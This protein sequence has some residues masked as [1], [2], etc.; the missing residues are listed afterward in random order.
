MTNPNN[1]PTW[2]AFGA[3]FMA[4][5]VATAM[6]T[7]PNHAARA[8]APTCESYPSQ[9]DAQI[10]YR[11]SS[12][13]L[14]Q[15]DRDLD[16]I[17]C[18]D[19]QPPC[20]LVEVLGPGVTAQRPQN[21]TGPC[22]QGSPPPG[23]SP[24]ATPR[25]AA[26]PP[27]LPT[28]TPA[29]APSPGAGQSPPPLAPPLP[30]AAPAASLRPSLSPAPALPSP[31]SSPQPPSI[32]Q[33]GSTLAQPPEP[34]LSPRPQTSPTPAP[35]SAPISAAATD[36]ASASLAAALRLVDGAPESVCA[37]EPLT[38]RIC[39]A[40][41][42]GSD[43]ER[44]VAA[45]SVRAATG[46]GAGLLVLGRDAAGAWG[47]WFGGQQYYQPS[48]LPAS[49]RICADGV[50]ANIRAAPG[51]EADR[52]DTLPDLTLLRAEAFVLTEPGDL[53]AGRAGAGWY[54]L[55][56]PEE[57]W[58]YSTLATS[59]QMEDCTLR[60]T[61][62]NAPSPPPR[63]PVSAS[64]LPGAT[65]PLI[66]PRPPG[67]PAP[68]VGETP[69]DAISAWTIG[70]F[71]GSEYAGACA[72]AQLPRDANKVC[73]T[74]VGEQNGLRA[75]TIGVVGIDAFRYLFLSQSPA[76]WTVLS[77]GVSQTGIPWP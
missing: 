55:S 20:D 66:A 39:V 9:R 26:T 4:L 58:I 18:E 14:S 70:R 51:I 34:S 22:G 30:T 6:R 74:F 76:G 59:T 3:L 11:A 52:L 21:V 5:A 40:P 61:L 15:L 8:Q 73:S 56:A 44:G 27:A 32:E 71:P 64:G 38:Q 23:S 46:P 2:I 42:A 45:F 63:P 29:L 68:A 48:T 16:G 35:T 36:L 77:T 33:R 25:P 17:A 50:G 43:T 57:G 49:L 60:D 7:A 13:G 28:P 31:P 41:V 37:L 12:G 10:A 72:D 53:D 65:P 24:P 67:A 47:Y 69:E 19:N 54:A 62:V 75:F 1:R